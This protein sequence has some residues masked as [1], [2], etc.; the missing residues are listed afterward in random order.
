VTDASPEIQAGE[1]AKAIVSFEAVLRILRK[2]ID[3]FPDHDLEAIVVFLTVSAASTGRHLRDPAVL[4]LVDHAPLPD[5][6]HGTISGRAVAQAT[7][8]PR[9]AVRRRIDALVKSGLLTREAHGV[10]TGAGLLSED[11]ILDF[12]RFTVR[13]LSTVSGRLGRLDRD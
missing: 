2:A 6:L 8:L 10:R 7:G 11:H 12:A 1:R 9:E 4:D 13:E 5:H 3:C